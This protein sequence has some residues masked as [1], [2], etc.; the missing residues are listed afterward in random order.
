MQ[1]SW[2]PEEGIT[3]SGVGVAVDCKPPYTETGNQFYSSERAMI[4]FSPSVITSPAP[5][6]NSEQRAFVTFFP[7][8]VENKECGIGWLL[9]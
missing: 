7:F 5:I 3:P 2:V 8:S 1:C 6:P 4:P 9:V